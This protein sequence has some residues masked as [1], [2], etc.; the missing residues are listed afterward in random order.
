MSGFDAMFLLA[1][2]VILGLVGAYVAVRLQQ[3]RRKLANERD[4][5]ARMEQLAARERVVFEEF[6]IRQGADQSGSRPIRALTD[7]VVEARAG[8]DLDEGAVC[9]I[10]IFE[11]GFT[12]CSKSGTRLAIVPLRQIA[13]F[14][15]TGGANTEST[16][17]VGGGIG[18]GG[19]IQGMLIAE[20][21]NAATRTVWIDTRIQLAWQNT[22]IAVR[23]AQV[24]P[25]AL[26]SIRLKLQLLLRESTPE[27]L[28]AHHA[29]DARSGGGGKLV[30]QLSALA[31][32]HSQGKLSDAE[33]AA[34]KGQLFGSNS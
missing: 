18:L 20:A 25:A 34:A 32:M 2:L 21:V 15:C 11:G 10:V 27:Q 29:P 28:V 5:K 33:F 22:A 12:I 13:Q 1:V 23:T 17:L 9:D 26:D 3:D 16:G 30:G 8:I 14:E 6:L 19:A 7:C 24:T 31:E 4:V